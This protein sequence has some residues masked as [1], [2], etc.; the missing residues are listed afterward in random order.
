MEKA[1]EI[2]ILYSGGTDS[3]CSASIMAKEYKILHLLTFKRLGFYSAENSQ[4]NVDLL[5]EKFPSNTFIHKIIDIEHLA[6]HVSSHNYLRNIFKYGFYALSNCLLCALVNH[7]RA[8]AYCIDNQIY[9]VADGITKEWPL[10]PSHMEKSIREFRNMYEHFNINYLTPVYEFE[11]EPSQKFAD[12][13]KFVNNQGQDNIGDKIYEKKST[14]NYM[15]KLGFFSSQ[16]VK[17]SSLD[18][19]IQPQCF[20]F[21]LHYLYLHWHYM[22]FKSYSDFEKMTTQFVKEKIEYFIR[23]IEEQ[24]KKII[25]ILQ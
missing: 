10:L 21:I 2:A 12:R 17:G 6:R 24:P 9:S 23:L 19:K 22:P 8:L 14:G 7:F 15:F 18:H 3:T 11:L 13:L 4:R 5:K 1:K 16:N 25:K 20:Q